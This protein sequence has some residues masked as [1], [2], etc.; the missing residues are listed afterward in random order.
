MAASVGAKTG[1]EHLALD[2]PVH[3]LLP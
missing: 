3:V 1:N 2:H